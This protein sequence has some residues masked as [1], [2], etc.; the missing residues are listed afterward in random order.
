[1]S[2]LRNEE[3]MGEE[4]ICGKGFC[5]VNIA[6]FADL[7]ENKKHLLRTHAVKRTLK[8]G[9]YLLREEDI[10]TSIYIIREGR[11][12]MN[13]F[14]EEGKEYISDIRTEGETIGEEDFLMEEPS[15]YN[16]VCVTA[17]A[18]C[19]IRKDFFFEMLRAEPEIAWN[20]IKGLS[21]KLDA[22]NETLEIL[23]ESDAM[24]RVVRFLLMRN[25]R[26]HEKNIVLTID[27]IAAS[28]GLRKET[29]SRKLTELMREGL[30]RRLGQRNIELLDRMGLENKIMGE[31]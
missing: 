12:K 9:E 22:A 18:L 30:I 20:M 13:R 19:E 24:S 28:V 8:R 1:M 4:C 6:L 16:A 27:D 11:V 23:Q 10:V 21:R 26:I 2:L 5:T 17:V 25:R 15:L 29:V 3:A 7:S 14:D 31:S